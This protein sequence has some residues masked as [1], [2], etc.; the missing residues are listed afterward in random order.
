M[1]NLVSKNLAGKSLCP[2][3]F[4]VQTHAA[5]KP[6]FGEMCFAVGRV[7]VTA[8]GIAYTGVGRA[9]LDYFHSFQ[10]Q[11]QDPEREHSALYGI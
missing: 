1:Q 8:Q 2:R 6:D 7:T 4:F 10:P 11:I 9:H 5:M 3:N